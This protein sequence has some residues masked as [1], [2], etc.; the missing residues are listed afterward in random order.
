MRWSPP[1][2]LWRSTLT[3]YLLDSTN[4]AAFQADFDA[5]GVSTR[6]RQNVLDYPFGESSGPLVFLQ[7]Y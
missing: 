2:A 1:V 5:M 3:Y 4:L 7:Y 6:F